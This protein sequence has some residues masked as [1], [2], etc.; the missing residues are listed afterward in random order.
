M[1]FSCLSYFGNKLLLFRSMAMEEFV[2]DSELYN[3]AAEYDSDMDLLD[4]VEALEGNY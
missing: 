3:A 2:S 1:Q 4:A